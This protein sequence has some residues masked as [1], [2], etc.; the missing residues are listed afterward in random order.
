MIYFLF[1]FFVSFGAYSFMVGGVHSLDEVVEFVYFNIFAIFYFII[2]VITF[3]ILFPFL[4][5]LLF[6]KGVI[7]FL[8]TLIRGIKY[9]FK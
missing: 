8:E 7:D 9:I 6:A 1:Y 4:V 2:L 3:S 5:I